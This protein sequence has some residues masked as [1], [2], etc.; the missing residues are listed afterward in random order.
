M[1]LDT[2]WNQSFL[3]TEDPSD[4][5]LLRESFRIHGAFSRMW[6]ND[7]LWFRDTVT[8]RPNLQSKKYHWGGVLRG[9]PTPQ[10]SWRGFSRYRTSPRYSLA[11]VVARLFGLCF[12][13]LR[14]LT[15]VEGRGHAPCVGN[16]LFVFLYSTSLLGY[17]C[18]ASEICNL[19]VSIFCFLVLFP[20]SWQLPAVGKVHRALTRPQNSCG[21][22]GCS[23]RQLIAFP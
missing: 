3:E 13:P 19:L 15:P 4:C 8:R 5:V 16:G 10:L 7:K 23:D 22:L 6:Q 1:L 12:G 2:N 11:Q 17:W 20:P 14:C 21:E 9:K 18:L